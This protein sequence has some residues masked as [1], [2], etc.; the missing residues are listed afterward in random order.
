MIIIGEKYMMKEY[1]DDMPNDYRKIVGKIGVVTGKSY[2]CEDAGQAYIFNCEGLTYCLYESE[3]SSV[4]TI[5]PYKLI[6][7]IKNIKLA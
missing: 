7:G 5:K 4:I 6:D 1:K 2:K 3:L